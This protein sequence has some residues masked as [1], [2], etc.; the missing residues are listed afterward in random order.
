MRANY[1]YELEVFLPTGEPFKL[2]ISLPEQFPMLPPVCELQGC[3][4]AHTRTYLSL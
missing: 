2:I 3:L 1:E 4:Q